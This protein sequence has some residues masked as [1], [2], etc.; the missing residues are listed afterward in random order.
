MTDL[1]SL[2]P[3]THDPKEVVSEQRLINNRLAVT[4]KRKV[5]EFTE[6]QQTIIAHFKS[7]LQAI[8]YLETL[9]RPKQPSRRRTIII[10]LLLDLRTVNYLLI[11]KG[12]TKMFVFGLCHLLQT[13][14]LNQK[15]DLYKTIFNVSCVRDDQVK[16]TVLQHKAQ[17]STSVSELARFA[18]QFQ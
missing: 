15:E 11:E 12:W 16:K 6:A 7:V 10:K 1:T 3:D 9:Y 5:F 2:L 4:V 18:S 17:T 14:A 8:E 13:S